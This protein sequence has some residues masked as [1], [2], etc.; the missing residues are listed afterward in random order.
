MPARKPRL[1]IDM[2]EVIADPLSKF[3]ALYSRDYGIEIPAELEAGKEIF[4][5]VPENIN[6]KWYDYI[7]EPGFFRDLPLIPGSQETIKALHDKYDVY[8]VSAAM[9]F[10]NSLTDKFDWLQEHF[11]FISWKNIVFCG[12]KIIDADVM[13]DDRIKNFASFDGRKLLFTSPHNLLITEYERVNTWQD[14]AEKLL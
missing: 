7:N 3:I 13:I 5:M 1:A 10:R 9:Q 2:D 14:V 6:R 8:I 12:D 4:Q 11:S